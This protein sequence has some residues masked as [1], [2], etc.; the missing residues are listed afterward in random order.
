MLKT[1]YRSTIAEMAFKSKLWMVLLMISVIANALLAAKMVMIDTRERI[2]IH[3]V[4]LMQSYSVEGDEVDPEYIGKLSE[5]F[6]RARFLYTP[7]T[8]SSQF[9]NLVRYFHPAIYG[10]KKAELDSEAAK[11]I[12]NEETSVFFPMSTHIKRKTAYVE[13]EITGFIGKKAVARSVRTF[14]VEFK[15][16]GERL[17]IADWKE[18]VPEQDG[19][20]YRRVAEAAE[21]S[22]DGSGDLN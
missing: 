9:N 21:E 13:A 12:R 20:S 19:K 11:I 1:K 8:V 4:T 17:W 7:S 10:E 15:D 22:T 16:S 6:L 14:E 3:P 18:V 2:V 5:E